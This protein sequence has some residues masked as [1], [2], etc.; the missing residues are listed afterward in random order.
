MDVLS[1]L[2]LSVS[3][4]FIIKLLKSVMK[5]KKLTGWMDNG[6]PLLLYFPWVFGCPY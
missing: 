1:H 4:F 3:E 6:L 2:L 5:Y